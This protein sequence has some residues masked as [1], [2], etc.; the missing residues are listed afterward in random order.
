MKIT[1]KGKQALASNKLKNKMQN[2]Q[3]FVEIYLF[4]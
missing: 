3:I 2:T 4:I 1:K